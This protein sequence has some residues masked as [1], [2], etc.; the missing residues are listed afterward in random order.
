VLAP[1]HDAQRL[2]AD[3]GAIVRWWQTSR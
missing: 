3:F 1:P 2:Q